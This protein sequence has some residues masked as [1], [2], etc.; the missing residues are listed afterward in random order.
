MFWEVGDR[1]VLC[2]A[3]LAARTRDRV[4]VNARASANLNREAIY[5]YTKYISLFRS[6]TPLWGENYREY[7]SSVQNDPDPDPSESRG[8]L[9]KFYVACACA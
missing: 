7:Q 9:W 6:P 1:A 2:C 8:L 3:V 4:I 5:I